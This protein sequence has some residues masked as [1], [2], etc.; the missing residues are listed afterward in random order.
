MDTNLAQIQARLKWEVACERLAFALHPPPGAPEDGALEI[1]AC[2]GLAQEAL[3]ELKQ[4]FQL[5]QS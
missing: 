4:A 2:V 5:D 3:Q 1:A